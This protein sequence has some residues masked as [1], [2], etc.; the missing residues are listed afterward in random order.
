MLSQEGIVLRALRKAG[1]HGVANY[2]FPELRV[3]CYTKVISDLR[4]DGYNITRERVKLP[5]GKSTQVH[6][7][8]L[9][10]ED[11]SWFKSLWRK[12]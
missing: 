9:M 7:Y 5:N 3:L 12:K 10:E 4:K 1:K 2:K 6:K 8:F 11:E